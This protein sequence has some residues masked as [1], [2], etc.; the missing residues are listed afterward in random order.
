MPRFELIRTSDAGAQLRLQQFNLKTSLAALPASR[1][2]APTISELQQ[3]PKAQLHI[4]WCKVHDG[5]NPFP[6]GLAWQVPDQGPA[7]GPTPS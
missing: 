2:K 6:T 7:A 1:L 5:V 4:N 3:P